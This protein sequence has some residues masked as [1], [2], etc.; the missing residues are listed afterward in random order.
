MKHLFQYLSIWLAFEQGLENQTQKYVLQKSV[1]EFTPPTERAWPC[2]FPWHTRTIPHVPLATTTVFP[3]LSSWARHK[4]T[5]HS[6]ANGVE[7]TAQGS[8]DHSHSIPRHFCLSLREMRTSP[9]SVKSSIIFP[10]A[11]K[12]TFMG[13]VPYLLYAS[14]HAGKELH[15]PI[16]IRQVVK[17]TW[18][19][20]SVSNSSTLVCIENINK[21]FDITGTKY[22]YLSF[23][24]VHTSLPF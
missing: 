14:Y 19:V 13:D 10:T 23:P 24:I 20:E 3:S 7:S 8:D 16:I 9:T 1:I 2:R 12:R 15:K 21:T 5:A 11:D 4:Q 18:L 6:N 17:S 22:S